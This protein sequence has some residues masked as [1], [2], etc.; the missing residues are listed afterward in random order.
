MLNE[1]FQPNA[2]N[3]KGFK[4]PT[5]VLA[6]DLCLIGGLPGVA[7]DS[8]NPNTGGTTFRFEGI[9]GL[10][11]IAAT[12][13]SPITGSTVNPGDKLYATG[14][15]DATTNVTT[16][17]TIS[18]ASGGKQASACSQVIRHW[19]PAQPTPTRL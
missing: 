15:F 7:V 12:V 4:C 9:F 19:H 14:I 8:Y 10:T 16:N 6:G 18:K 3:A 11:V 17:L 1:R 2:A 5:T 13:V